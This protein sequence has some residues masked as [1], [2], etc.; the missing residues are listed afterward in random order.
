M[1]E[2]TCGVAGPMLVT[3]T[4][5][6]LCEARRAGLRRLRFLS[7][8]GQVLFELARI[9][10]PAL[11]VDVDL[12]YVHGNRLTWSLAAADAGRLGRPSWLFNGLLEFGP[13]EL[14]AR[15]KLP[16]AFVP[17]LVSAGFTE[18]SIGAGPADREARA[19]GLREFLGLEPVVAAL[20]AT[21]G[22]ARRLLADYA[23]QHRLLDATTAMVDTGWVGRQVDALI[24]VGGGPEGERPR[25][26]FWGYQPSSPA[27]ADNADIFRAYM[28]NT[29]TGHGTLLPDAPFVM[30]MFCT[31]DHGTLV[32]YVRDPDGRVVPVLAA[33]R[34]VAA[35]Q[36]GLGRYRAALYCFAEAVAQRCVHWDQDLRSM[37]RRLLEL[38]WHHPTAAEAAIW[39]GFPYEFTSDGS[40]ITSVARPLRDPAERVRVDD[41]PWLAGSLLLGDLT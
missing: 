13:A 22:S 1:N 38:F 6:V 7:R 26:L 2:V 5:W 27:Q 28:Y 3:Y 37:V 18:R 40:I 35:E 4:T 15:L 41:P 10:A 36:W 9:L 33:S 14:C 12:E 19:A 34:N 21:V 31:S 30:E 16:A 11:D 24:A 39:G 20:S 17:R 23:A 8:E 29:V 32:E 25:V